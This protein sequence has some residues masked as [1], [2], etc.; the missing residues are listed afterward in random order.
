MLLSTVTDNLKS[1]IELQKHKKYTFS[2]IKYIQEPLRLHSQIS[3]L[4]TKDGLSLS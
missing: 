1:K 2:S 4:E 3:G